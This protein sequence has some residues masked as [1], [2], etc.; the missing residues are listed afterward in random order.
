MADQLRGETRVELTGA[1][2]A[3]CHGSLMM[4]A[5]DDYVLNGKIPM[6]GEACS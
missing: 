2:S 6:D 5:A 3:Y 1:R 4:P